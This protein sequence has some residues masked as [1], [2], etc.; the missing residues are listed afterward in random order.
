MF[1]YLVRII[2]RYRIVNLGVIFLITCFMAYKALDVELSYEFAQMLPKKNPTNVNYQNF[3]KIFGEDGAVMFIAIQNDSIF[4]FKD[5]NDWYN[6]TYRLKTIEGVQEVISIGRLFR[7]VKNDRE[8]KFTFDL[9]VKHNPASQR[10]VD[11]IQEMIHSLPFYE[12]MLYNKSTGVTLMMITLDKQKL[13]TRNRVALINEI[14]QVTGDY[15][16]AHNIQ[17]HYSG[18]PFIRTKTS[19][20]IQHELVLFVILAMAIASIILFIFFRSLKAV[21]F[22]MI[23]VAISV[24]W[25]MGTMVIF[26]YKISI[27]TGI[28]PPLLIVIVVENCIFLLNKYH[29]EFLL[30][31]NKIKALSRMVQRIGNANLL[32]N[33]ATAA[34]FLS[35][36]ITGNR[37]LT[38]FGI[39][40]S[41]NILIAYLLCLF[42]VPIIFSYLPSPK[43]RHIRHLQHSNV[44]KIIN[45]IVLIVQVRRSR[46][47]IITGIALAI[48]VIGISL[49]KSSGRIVDDI[50]PREQMYKDLIY[51]EN[52][53][54]GV[55][56]FEISIDTK[57][58]K[59][60]MK[61]A[62]I[63]KINE[64]QD[65]LA[66]YPELSKSLSLADVVKYARQA[67][68]NGDQSYYGMPNNQEMNF[69]MRYLPKMDQK[70]K[71][72]INSFIDTNL[73]VTRITAQMA[74]I[75]TIE[76]QRIKDD[77]QPKI[78]SIFS[79]EDFDVQITGTSIVFQ[80][81]SKYLV[82]HLIMSLLLAV[83]IISLLMALLFTSVRMILIS[84]IP[85]LIPLILTAGM[86]GFFGITIKP[87][88]VLI[89]SIALGISVD[90]AI[91]Y[92]SRYRLNL[93]FNN[94]Q[95]K[96]SVLAAL[97]ETGFSMIYS[98]VV[99]FFG[100]AIFISSSFGGTVAL[101]YLISF[102]LLMALLCNLFILPSLLLTMDKFIT[103]R[104]FR[105]PLLDIFDEEI[106]I[107]LEELEIEKKI[108][109]SE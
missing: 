33:A 60:A 108:G 40:A 99:L 104:S 34:G 27:L 3:K 45:R 15:G 90:N 16:K 20:K 4:K 22:T 11:S 25:L 61:L 105:E 43:P 49:L 44:S 74:N 73:Q 6:L 82:N 79:K 76:I 18:L 50:S 47:Y 24:T 51:L 17:V 5:F 92:L 65:V 38:E 26:G 66:A 32:T 55:M 72:I 56:P 68:Y 30:H 69:M 85:N 23:I 52:H 58:K 63:E 62:T 100:F 78:D 28:L 88:T 98:S 87:S 39:I 2:L 103:T 13:N 19:E 57:K 54:N 46:I 91:Q 96:I 107:E 71:T 83:A 9:I 10:E 48:G 36:I 21:F 31:G 75:G 84:I 8:K 7:L 14:V 12:G 67:F 89:F 81:G 53:F 97:K 95:I 93:I 42:L 37:L 101:G 86:M 41:I 29:H 59:G 102:T 109:S 64:L 1:T 80:E 35:F 70:K 106:D 94:W 77:L